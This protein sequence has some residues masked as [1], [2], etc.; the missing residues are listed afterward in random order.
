[1]CITLAQLFL[2]KTHLNRVKSSTLEQLSGGTRFL[3][4]THLNWAKQ[5]MDSKE[6]EVNDR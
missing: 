4:V 5:A 2:R 1:M 6:K 3:G